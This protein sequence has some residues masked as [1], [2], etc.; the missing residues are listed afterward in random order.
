MITTLSHRITWVLVVCCLATTLAADSYH[1][2][3]VKSQ[4]VTLDAAVIERWANSGTP[5]PLT[6]GKQ[7]MNVVLGPAPVFPAEGLRFLEIGKNGS[8]KE[9]VLQGNFTYAG[10]IVGED[11]ATTEVRLTIADGQVEGYVLSSTGWW[12]I[13]PLVRFDPKA[14]SDRY[15]VYAAHDTDFAVDLGND[16][17]NSEV[18]DYPV[19]DDKIPLVMVADRE[20]LTQSGGSFAKVMQRQAALINGVNGIYRM[21]FGREFRV[22]W[23]VLDQGNNLVATGA[24]DL[25]YQLKAFM[26]PQRLVQLHCHVAHLTTGKNLD[27]GKLGLGERRGFRSL[28]KQ[29]TTLAFRN[30]VIA[31]RETSRNFGSVNEEAEEHCI[32]GISPCLV[33]RRTL[34]SDIF[35]ETLTVAR[36]SDG[37]LGP[38]HNNVQRMC[39]ILAERG[40][41]C[42]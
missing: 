29:S 27:F 5:F 39:I 41:P 24:L 17:V 38:D 15:L 1:P 18:F 4:V 8:E 9:T 14:A 23:A 32:P 22:P 7:T 37:R 33:F 3:I 10:E 34:D 2:N 20:Y 35:D 6:L 26:T 16:N 12:F 31:A 19:K 21:Q 36:F 30:E 28:S 42:Q 25:L 11:P 13:E 40:F